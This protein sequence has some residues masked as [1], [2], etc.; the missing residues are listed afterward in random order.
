MALTDSDNR[1]EYSSR[2]TARKPGSNGK[3]AGSNKWWSDNQKIECVKTYLILG[4]L[5]QTARLLKIPDPTVRVWRASQWWKDVEGELKL[6]DEL[7]LTSRLKKTLGSVLDVVDD[8]VASGDFVYD[9]KSGQMRRKPISA[10]DANKIA[11]DFMDRQVK[12]ESNQTTLESKEATAD[13]LMKLAQKFAELAGA[14]KKEETLVLENDGLSGDIYTVPD[15]E[16][17]AELAEEEQSGSPG[18][19]AL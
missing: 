3:Q 14:A 8:R 1:Q 11:Q 6:Q 16:A 2:V 13:K 18:F 7:Q 9:Q 15:E 17:D 12:L 19:S 5:S 4:N 10:R